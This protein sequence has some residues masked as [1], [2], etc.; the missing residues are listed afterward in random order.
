MTKFISKCCVCGKVYCVT[1]IP[2]DD[3]EKI[4]H[5]Y[6]STN[7]SGFD[8]LQLLVWSDEFGIRVPDQGNRTISG[9]IYYHGEAVDSLVRFSRK[10]LQVE[11]LVWDG[12]YYETKDVVL[13]D[14]EGHGLRLAKEAAGQ[15]G[16]ILV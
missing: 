9:R 14:N 16:T 2:G 4:S 8:A 1:S 13:A 6:C 11:K 15:T 10:E 3:E 12:S 5:G 7:C